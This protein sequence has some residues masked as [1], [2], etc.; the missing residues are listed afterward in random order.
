[1][2]GAAKHI[3]WSAQDMKCFAQDMKWSAQDVRIMGILINFSGNV[4]NDAAII[5]EITD[6]N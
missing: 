6:G 1:V 4:T 5:I 3:K 2:K